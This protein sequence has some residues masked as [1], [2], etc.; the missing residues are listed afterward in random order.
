MNNNIKETLR[1]PQFQNLLNKNDAT[2]IVS[3][4]TMGSY[5]DISIEY[6][7]SSDEKRTEVEGSLSGAIGFAAGKIGVKGKGKIEE[8]CNFRGERLKISVGGSTKKEIAIH[9]VSCFCF[10]FQKNF[11]LII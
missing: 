2:H 7:L 4:V 11:S 3:E 9:N 5:L 10:L 8:Q 6:E 1:K